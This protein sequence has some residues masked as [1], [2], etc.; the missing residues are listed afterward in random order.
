M[1]FHW[2]SLTHSFKTAD[3]SALNYQIV[4]IIIINLLLLLLLLLLLSHYNYYLLSLFIIIIIIIII[5]ISLILT[6]KNDK[7]KHHCYPIK[8]NTSI[9]III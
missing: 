2:S 3:S 7:I 5:T 4:I 9:V 8:R 6:P 1:Q